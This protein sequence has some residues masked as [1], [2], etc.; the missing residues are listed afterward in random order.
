[1]IF[2]WTKENLP[3]MSVSWQGTYIAS[4]FAAYGTNQQFAPFYA[5]EK[6]NMLSILDGKAVL[7]GETIDIDEWAIFLSMHP[8][9]EVVTSEKHFAQQ[10][11]EHF[12]KKCTYKTVMRL[13]NA[14][15]P[16]EIPLVSPTPRQMYPLLLEVFGDTMPAFDGWY[17]DVSHRMRHNI[18]KTAGIEREGKL[19][20]TAMTVAESA[21]A[22]IVGA[23][24]T[25]ASHRKMGLASQC[26]RGLVADILTK[27]KHKTIMI[28]PKNSGAERLYA[29]MGFAVCG[30]I[31]EMRIRDDKNGK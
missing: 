3:R 5:D 24:A 6:G 17:V 12:Q 30:E 18:C 13:E 25:A 2:L 10:L 23:V 26:L 8:E 16:V 19:V 7:A 4:R 28:S 21:D 14:L 29:S 9:I 20:S 1:M 15:P 31:G 22:A 27:N 11:A